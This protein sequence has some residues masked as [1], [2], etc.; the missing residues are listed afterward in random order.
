[1][2]RVWQ[3]TFFALGTVNTITVFERKDKDIIDV[4][5]SLVKELEAQLSV[6]ALNSNISKINAAAGKDFVRLDP[7]TYALIKDAIRFSQISE[8]VFDITIQPLIALWEIGKQK[9]FIPGEK[10]IKQ[11]KRLVDY[12]DILFRDEDGSIMLRRKEQ[13]ISLGSIAKGYAV[14]QAKRILQKNG[15]ANGLINFGGEVSCFGDKR[16]VGI[17]NPLKTNGQAIAKL[18]ISNQAVVT[19]GVYQKGFKLD[20]TWYHHLLDPRSGY[21]S[22]RGLQSVTLIGES[23]MEMDALA[24]VVLV[25]GMERGR[26]LLEQYQAEAVFVNDSGDIL[27]TTGIKNDIILINKEKDISRCEQK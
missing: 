22:Q 13:A 1:M 3:K 21:P 6:Y 7:K 18:P 26:Q 19:S 8:G 12:Q 14:D 17:Q 9:S 4:A 23:A 5:I 27:A 25:M 20:G 15:V 24:T 16:W 10:K 2:S 11:A